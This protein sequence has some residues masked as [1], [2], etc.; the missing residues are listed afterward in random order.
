MFPEHGR[1]VPFRIENYA[2]IDPLGRETV[3]WV[4]TFSTKHKRRFDAYMIFSE[5]RGCIIDYLGTHQHLEV[6]I[7]VSVADNGGLRLRSGEQRFYEGPAAFRFPWLFTRVADVCEWYDDDQESFC[8]DVSAR[9]RIR[10]GL[11][12]YPG[13]FTVDWVKMAPEQVPGTVR[14]RSLLK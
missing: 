3:N 4:R 11:F 7:Q 10:G 2:Y 12:G 9:H 8:I 14:P 13:R 5:E 6:D 1:H